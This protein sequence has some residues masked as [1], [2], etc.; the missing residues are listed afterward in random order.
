MQK[1]ITIQ[2]QLHD[3]RTAIDNNSLREIALE[4]KLRF[5]D[6]KITVFNN[7]L[8]STKLKKINFDDF[9]IIVDLNDATTASINISNIEAL[10]TIRKEAAMQFIEQHCQR[11]GLRMQYQEIISQIITEKITIN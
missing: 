11:I 4:K 7:D 10:D 9:E 5:L 3:L 2:N 6:F 8:V 1:T